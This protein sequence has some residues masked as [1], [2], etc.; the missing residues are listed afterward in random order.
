MTTIAF[1][2]KTQTNQWK[3][4]DS[5]EKKS[6]P[7]SAL[8][9][10]NQIYGEALRTGNSSD[11]IKAIIYQLKYETLIDHDK[12]PDK[13]REIERFTDKDKNRAEQAILYSLLS[14][15]YNKYY[16]AY[17]YTIHQRTALTTDP[18]ENEDIREWPA[19]LFI[20]KIAN[21]ASR[22]LEP[23]QLLQNIDVLD[24]KA[25]IV[26]GK[27]SRKIRPA[28]YDFLAGRAIEILNR[29]NTDSRTQNYF[30]QTR[31]SGKVFYA[32]AK[33]FVR[34]D[35]QANEC[36]FAPQILKM[37]QNLLSFRLKNNPE[38]ALLIAD[39]NRLS[40]INRNT[41]SMSDENDYLNA[42][43]FL[44]EQYRKNDFCVEILYEKACYYR[45]LPYNDEKR[46]PD[47]IK[48][49]Y[50]VC[51]KGINDYPNYE[52]IGLLQNMLNELTNS[53]LYVESEN[54]VYP[55]NNLTLRIH[56]KNFKQLRIE[57]Y[58]IKANI[59]DYPLDWSRGGQYNHKGTLIKKEITDLDNLT[60]YLYSDT[61]IQIPMKELGFYEYVIY[62]DDSK[63]E[64]ANRQ[65]SVSRLA[66]VAREVDNRREFLVV[67]R[68]SGKPVPNVKIHFYVRSN[69]TLKRVDNKMLITD[70]N[71]LASC[72]DDKN[73]YS[74]NASIGNDSA[75]ITSTLPWISSYRP[76][77]SNSTL[78][79]LFTDRSIYRP[80]QIVYFK[81]IAYDAATDFLRISPN[82]NYTF[83]F[84]DANGK[85][86]AAQ[87]LTTGEF[88]S[89]SGSFLI[90]Q[91]ALNGLYEIASDAG[92][93]SIRVEEYKR[94]SFD[95]SFEPNDKTYQFGDK[96]IIKGYARTFSGVNLQETNVRYRITRNPY[97]LYRG[98]NQSRVQ[99]A[100]GIVQ[101]KSDGSFEIVFQPEKAFEDRQNPETYYVYT[102]EA[103]I[104]DN[105]GESQSSQSRYFIGDKSIYLSVSGL[106][107]TVNKNAIPSVSIDVFNLSRTP[108]PT[109]GNYQIY[110]LEP[111]NEIQL[112]LKPEDWKQKQ[113][114]FSGVFKSGEVLDWKTLKSA[115]SGQ[116]R[117]I[118]QATDE[119]GRKTEIQQDFT[120]AS[121]NDKKPPVPTYEWLMAPVTECAV[122]EKAEI[123]YGSSAK[124]VYVL[125]E[126]FKGNKKIACSRFVLNN[127][128]KK[129]EIPFL[130][131]YGEKITAALCFVKDEKFFNQKI[132]INR[133]QEN[134][135]LSL[136][137]EVFRDR[138]LPGQKEEWKISVKNAENHPV[139]AELLTAM[140]D[141]AL[142]KLSTHSWTF[143]PRKPIF[144][145][146]FFNYTGREF[147]SSG[148]SLD[149]PMQP[150][151]INSVYD[152]FNWFNFSIY[153]S[154]VYAAMRSANDE[155]SEMGSDQANLPAP[156]AQ[157]KTVYGAESVAFIPPQL[158]EKTAP[159][160][161]N[162]EETAFFY[163]HLK[164]NDDGET[165]ITFVLPESNTQWKFMGLA[166]TADLKHGQIIKEVISQKKL[167]VTP[168]IPRFMRTGDKMTILSSISN[169]SEKDITGTV[170]IECFDPNTNKINIKIADS[171]K[172]FSIEA[173]KS[174]SVSWDMYIPTNIDITMLKIV[175]RSLD[176]SDGE[177]HP[178]PVLPS[179]MM[180]TESLPLN[181]YGGQTQNFFF[182]RLAK[183]HSSSLENYRLTLEFA[184]NPVW[185]AV[186]ALPSIAMPQ[187]D[188]VLSWFAAYF[189]NALAVQIANSTPKIRQIID[190]WTKQ[191]GSKETLLS[192]LEKNQELKSILL[193]ETPWVL[194]AKNE[195]EQKQR[196][197]SLFD[198]NR[199]NHLNMLAVEK[200]KSFQSSDGGWEWFKGM[201]G[202]VPITQWILYG[203]K[204]IEAKTGS[205]NDEIM[206]MQKKAVHFIDRKFKKRYDDLKKDNLL[207]TSQFPAA[208]EM[209]YLFVRSF[210][211]NIPCDGNK[212]AIDFYIDAIEKYWPKNT[213]LYLCA[214]AAVIMQKNGK[215]ETAQAMI[216]S[217]REHATHKP[218][219]GMYWANNSTN[220]F[221]TQSAVCIHTFIMEAFREVGSKPDEMD[222]MKLWLL[223]Q[224]QTQYWESVPAT[225]NSIGVLLSEGSDWLASE[226]NTTIH[227]G[228]QTIDTAHGDAGTGYFKYVETEDMP[229]LSL[230]KNEKIT[231]SKQDP[232]P[233]WGAVYWQYFEDLDKIGSA[234]TGLNVEKSLFIEKITAAGKVLAPL[235]TDNPMKTGDKI[236]VRLT[237]HSDRD[238]EYVLLKDLRAS[239]F[240]PVDQLSGIRWMQGL[241]YYLSPKD[242][243]MNFF[244]PHIPK[245]T[246]VFEYNLYAAAPGDYSDG[247]A[248]IQCL[249]APEWVSHTSGGRVVVK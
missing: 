203:M 217:L 161:Q 44:E 175:A 38:E 113:I 59:S 134:K 87:K 89:L 110:S 155:A 58:K 75:L 225:V 10:V 232:G 246:Y 93:V 245:G 150:V 191:N 79:N 181:I 177:Q 71:G 13:I 116:Y 224:K 243:S 125:Y 17:S 65:F 62:A 210:Y 30:V 16:Q 85:E 123:I 166:H 72:S 159:V 235:S 31:F 131:S 52:R 73:L 231:V 5:L 160:R 66:T 151:D 55:G 199:S 92:G 97:W 208:Y 90:P 18:A 56:Y 202:N 114:V 149:R 179:R 169:L 96:A 100:D 173:G 63:K 95:I 171:S 68:Q 107:V 130:E 25:I 237:V 2:V 156:T 23:A 42:L 3:D 4:V 141:A 209:E 228:K 226:G 129:I 218:D 184:T 180:V 242:A 22:S 233:A 157:S 51:L 148:C 212:A 196:L 35:I 1:S 105:K 176:F 69:R 222:E 247:M 219:M 244:F 99:I 206:E 32:P 12:L 86:I 197:S 189:S 102:I 33:D 36:D 37:Y 109:E 186:Q 132:N 82:K 91:G 213:N 216:R 117:L 108:I 74:Y 154:V 143:N 40:F 236:T 49:A 76:P 27:Y 140:Y 215:L 24:Y 223:K 106:N 88:G 64:P 201:S 170:S 152:S 111:V 78:L 84:R 46:Q 21:L 26:E 211:K 60:P 98:W 61:T 9:V 238:V 145:Q 103:L 48:K 122:G 19:N 163:P 128:N 227:I 172:D 104:T 168:N 144:E 28:L 185:Y 135:N 194:D 120:W 240:E 47:N 174:V 167:M 20:R 214:I 41:S 205:E 164:T 187:S 70:N 139:L 57:I 45:N 239:C 229:S 115:P 136:K 234:K 178:V 127:E 53:H 230:W 204:K 138:L 192:N 34:M 200:L 6:L 50:T 11:L 188:N 146:T 39:L 14:E 220:C 183:N 118:A 193:E 147:G 121:T 8:Q 137:M 7:Q 207:T 158:G 241:I 124:N 221:M 80:G 248:T 54:V 43:S 249:Y 29:L 153:G 112:D 182:D 165:L 81:G 83:T 198:I 67:D 190:V 101:T 126:L 94:P 142:D 77:V 195:S 15:L 133:K 162:F 119:K